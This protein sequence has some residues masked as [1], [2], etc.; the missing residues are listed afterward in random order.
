MSHFL[1]RPM[2]FTHSRES[3]VDGHGEMRADDRKWEKGYRALPARWT[4]AMAR[5]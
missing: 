1:D 5:R 4:G 3:F 2:F